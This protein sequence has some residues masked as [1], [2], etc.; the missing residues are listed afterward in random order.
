[1]TAVFSS[2][3]ITVY[4]KNTENITHGGAL[5]GVSIGEVDFVTS[6]FFFTPERFSQIAIVAQVSTFALE[7]SIRF[8][9]SDKM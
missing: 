8:R 2:I 9:L 3:E 4:D 7:N 5:Q 1:M 6:V